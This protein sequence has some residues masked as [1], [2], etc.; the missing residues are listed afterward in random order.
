MQVIPTLLLIFSL[1][2]CDHQIDLNHSQT[3][4]SDECTRENK[5][6]TCKDVDQ[7]VCAHCAVDDTLNHH[8]MESVL[9]QMS[10][11]GTMVV[12]D[13]GNPVTDALSSDD[14]D[15]DD[16]NTED[17]NMNGAFNCDYLQVGST[18]IAQ[19]YASVIEATGDWENKDAA[20][21]IADEMAAYSP[22]LDAGEILTARGWDFCHDTGTEK[23]IKV[24][25]AVHG[26][27]Q[28]DSGRYDILVALSAVIRQQT[29]TTQVGHG[30]VLI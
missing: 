17:G 8:N 12:M 3:A 9:D 14:E 16:A 11:Q 26:R 2:A 27:T 19:R 5:T 15:M 20:R 30:L 23:I 29:G 10:N 13:M 24:E 7:A 4:R 25:L 18:H 22:N 6:R 1:I 28:Y 21:G